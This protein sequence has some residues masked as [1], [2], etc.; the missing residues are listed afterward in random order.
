[1]TAR[2]TGDWDKLKLTLG[3]LPAELR[4]AGVLATRQ[5]ALMLRGAIQEGIRDQA[6]GGVAFEKLSPVTIKHKKSSKALIDKGDL[7]RSI[8]VR[9][10][11]SGLWAFI[12]VLRSARN[13]KS[14]ALVNIALVHEYGSATKK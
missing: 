5:S 1:M 7:L 4:Q 6:P 13:R 10:G 8:S 2:L 9:F 11:K 12:G 14:K 3:R